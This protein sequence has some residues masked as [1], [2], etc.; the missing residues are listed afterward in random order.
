M[1]TKER[2][3]VWYSMGAA[4]PLLGERGDE[5]AWVRSEAEGMPEVSATD[6]D[7]DPSAFILCW[8][9]PSGEMTVESSRF[10]RVR[11]NSGLNIGDEIMCGKCADY[12]TTTNVVI[13]LGRLAPDYPGDVTC[14]RCRRPLDMP[15]L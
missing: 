4:Y 10:S 9:D 12:C 8:F 7:P 15:G 3:N 1:I 13:Q 14:Q 6:S 5:C 2:I 11:D